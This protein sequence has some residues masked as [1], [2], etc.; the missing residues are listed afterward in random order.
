[1][2]QAI[3]DETSDRR[4]NKRGHRANRHTEHQQVGAFDCELQIIG[5]TIDPERAGIGRR[6][7]FARP[8]S[9]AR[10]LSLRGKRQ[11]QRSAEQ[12]TAKNADVRKVGV[13]S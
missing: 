5:R 9:H 6:L 2:Q 4:R 3:A 1:M 11:G 10:G 8:Q 7:R 13:H 12:P